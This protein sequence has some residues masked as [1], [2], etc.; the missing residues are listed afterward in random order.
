MNKL[1][2]THQ[3]LIL[4]S[5]LSAASINAQTSDCPGPAVCTN[6]SGIMTPG[7]N[8]EINISNS[9]TLPIYEAA[10]SFWF[11]VCSST[12]GTIAFTINPSGAGNDYDFAVWGPGVFC[13]PTTQPIRCSYALTTGGGLNGDV[14]GL[15]N[16]A[17]DSIEDNNGDGWVSPIN[18][19]PGECYVVYIGNYVGGSNLFDIIFTGTA[20]LNCSLLPV[21]LLSFEASSIGDGIQLTWN[22]ES[23]TNNSH[24]I[25]ERTSDGVNYEFIA[26][27]EGAGTT[28]QPTMYMYEDLTA[29]EGTSYYRLTQVDYNGAETK[30]G[31]I[32]FE[33]LSDGPAIIEI[34]N[35]SGQMIFS[36][37]TSNYQQTIQEQNLSEG[38]YLIAITR[39]KSRQSFKYAV[40]IQ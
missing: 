18:A 2:L 32:A 37:E 10:T 8:N 21:T 26:R 23:E 22:C 6:Q 33:Y 35:M 27:V 36:S 14:T 17:S 13:A 7:I 34:M 31:P 39:G 11:P 4:S 40:P 9:G 3:I 15:S 24:F 29:P 19:L 30:Y 5:L 38:I 12:S 20:N 16:A 28:S 25:I 1:T